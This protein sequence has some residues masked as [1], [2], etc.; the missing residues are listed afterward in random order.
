MLEK[1]IRELGELIFY[2]L[3]KNKLSLSKSYI[4]QKFMIWSLSRPDIKVNLFRL[5]DVIPSL[6]SDAA[7]VEH[8]A[9]YLGDTAK[10]FS[11]IANW[12]ISPTPNSWRGKLT[13]L[14][15]RRSIYEMASLFIAGNSA[16]SALN[17]IRKTCKSGF[18]FTADLLGEY[19]VSSKESEAYL[20]RYLSTIELLGKE[21]T[22]SDYPKEI[23]SNRGLNNSSNVSVKLSA[24]YSQCNPLN[25]DRSVD[26]LSEKLSQ[27]VEAAIK[28]NVSIYVDAE[29][30]GRN[31]IIYRAFYNVFSKYNTFP[32]PGIVLQAYNKNSFKLAQE[33]IDFAKKNKN[34]I[35]IRLVKGA[36]WDYEYVSANQKGL[37]SPLYSHKVNTDA[38]YEQITKL[39][40]DNHE[41]VI[42][43]FGSHNIRSLSHACCYAKSIGL[44]VNDFELQMLFGMAQPIAEAFKSEGYLVRYYVPLGELLPGMGY[45]VRR[46][47]ENTSNESFL[48]HTFFDKDNVGN[49]LSKPEFDSKEL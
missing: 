35:A 25:F 31:P 19:S 11:S 16:E 45:L 47:L 38:N 39:L 29:D 15:I 41:H 32:F 40:L 13:A 12:A 20:Q 14:A 1:E 24:L 30:S 34:P 33:L 36:Y 9:E 2:K 44:T 27:I 28:N 17:T 46:L 6:K 7:V 4:N 5:V 8:V 43:A 49:L 37:R 18:T 23:L 42:P 26:V 21:I 10:E 3:S 22:H 48:K